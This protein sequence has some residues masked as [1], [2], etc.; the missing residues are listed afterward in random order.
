M[1]GLL[2]ESN[3]YE[4]ELAILLPITLARI[5]DTSFL[6]ITTPPRMAEGPSFLGRRAAYT[7]NRSEY[8]SCRNP[9]PWH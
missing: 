8:Y 1:F 2:I 6:S 3:I 4:R 9:S 5:L 7:A